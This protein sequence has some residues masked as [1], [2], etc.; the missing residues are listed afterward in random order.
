MTLKHKLFA[1]FLTCLIC[2]ILLI[3]ITHGGPIEAVVTSDNV[4]DLA[5]TIEE[6]VEEGTPGSY[7]DVVLALIICILL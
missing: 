5:S 6:A 1:V 4:P 2:A 7:W 3:Y